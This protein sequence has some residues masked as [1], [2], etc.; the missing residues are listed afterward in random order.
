MKA[1]CPR[2]DGERNCDIHGSF[3]QRWSDGSNSYSVDGY[4]EHRLL[5]CRGCDV[6]FYRSSSTNSEDYDHGY[7]PQTGEE[8]VYHTETV[9]TF[10]AAPVKGESG[11]P[12]WAWTIQKADH[13]LARIMD[14]VYSAAAAGSLILSSVGL[15]T[16]LDRCTEMVGI[17]PAISMQEKVKALLTG[18]WVGETEAQTLSVVAEAG[19]AAAH[20][21]WSP[22]TDEFKALLH[23]LEQFIE[24]AIM[25]G[26]DAL[27]V[28]AKIPA[29]PKRQ[30]ANPAPAKA[31]PSS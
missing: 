15:R 14:E 3:D 8:T 25:S 27:N 22:H 10:P 2:C 21:A 26:K 6:V 9:E 29:K 4:I 30:K 23:T 5:Q 20:R 11:R 18:G 13:T 19:N 12:D 24:R 17:D 28:A 31:A 1:H 16:A 7:D